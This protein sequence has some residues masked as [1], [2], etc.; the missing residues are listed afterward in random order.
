VAVVLARGDRARALCSRPA[1]IRGL[2]HRIE[3][4]QPGMRD[5]TVS[6][7]TTQAARKAGYDG[8]PIDV[9]ELSATFSPQELILR[10]ALDLPADT[11][12]NPS[13]GPLAANPVMAT[14]LVRI[15][16]VAQRIIDGEANRGLAHATGG[17]VLQHNLVCVM[18]GE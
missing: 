8:G 18:E 9:A 15:V 17:Q 11:E 10:A 13:G 12:V 6:P 4:H 16:E 3:V 7:S 1:W 2:D 5:L 14:G